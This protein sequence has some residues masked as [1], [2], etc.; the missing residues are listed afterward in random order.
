MRLSDSSQEAYLR[1]DIAYAKCV[2]TF[3][4]ALITGRPLSLKPK[5]Y[6][7]ECGCYDSRDIGEYEMCPHGCVYCCAVQN[8]ERAQM[9]FKEHD[10]AT[11]RCSPSSQQLQRAAVNATGSCHFYDHEHAR[12]NQDTSD[13]QGLGSDK[14]WDGAERHCRAVLLDFGACSTSSR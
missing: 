11:S 3:R 1:E 5:G 12:R 8:M 10:P 6:R 9:R 13:Q 14:P 7:P 2:D 4:L